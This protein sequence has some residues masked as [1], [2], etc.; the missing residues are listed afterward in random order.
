MK[1]ILA[2]LLVL[3]AQQTFAQ[4]N[5]ETLFSAKKNGKK[6]TIGAYGVPAAKFTP[7]DGKFGLLTGGYGGVLLNGKIMLGAGAYSLVNNV[8]TP[9]MNTAGYKEYVNLW[10]TGFV[11]EYI[12]NSDKLVHWTAGALLGGGGVGRRDKNRWENDDWDHNSVYDQ[13]GFFVAEPFANLEVNI[14]KFLRLDVGASY[15]YIAGSSTAGITDG[16]IGGPSLNIGLKAGK[17]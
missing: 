13:S 4:S 3:A 12:H 5:Q 2:A 16:K 17:F 7:I 14:T 9:T 1:K 10:Y 15:R 6:T 11:A 8:E